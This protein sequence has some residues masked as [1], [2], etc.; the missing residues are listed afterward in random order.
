MRRLWAASEGIVACLALGGLPALGD[1]TSERVAASADPDR[2]DPSREGR[3]SSRGRGFAASRHLHCDA[4]GTASQRR[5]H[6]TERAV[7][8]LYQ[9]REAMRHW[10]GRRDRAEPLADPAHVR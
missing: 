9:V 10:P 3:A 4:V 7:A 2:R 1:V 6:G 5:E 8:A